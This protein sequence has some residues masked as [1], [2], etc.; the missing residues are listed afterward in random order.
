MSRREAYI[1]IVADL[2]A[3]RSSLVHE[4][5]RSG[6]LEPPLRAQSRLSDDSKA[7]VD[8]RNKLH[9]TSAVPRNNMK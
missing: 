6:S 5:P 7:A 2:S 3:A 9:S 1:G 8:L 4:R